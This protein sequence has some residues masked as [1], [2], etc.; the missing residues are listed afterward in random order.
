MYR[1]MHVYVM[2]I[3][4]IVCHVIQYIYVRL[5][6]IITIKFKLNQFISSII[7]YTYIHGLRVCIFFYPFFNLNTIKRIDDIEG[8]SFFMCSKATAVHKKRVVNNGRI[9]RKYDYYIFCVYIRLL[10]KLV[11]LRLSLSHTQYLRV[12]RIKTIIF[13]YIIYT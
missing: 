9:Y 8:H 4:Y 12:I 10:S 13:C 5:E 11:S 1:I 3:M 2:Y 6:A 7:L